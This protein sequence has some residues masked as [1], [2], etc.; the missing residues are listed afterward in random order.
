MHRGSLNKYKGGTLLRK[1]CAQ[2][3]F[4][5]ELMLGLQWK[6][7]NKD[8]VTHCTVEVNKKKKLLLIHIEVILAFL[9]YYPSIFIGLHSNFGKLA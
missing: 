1:L 8:L 4:V 3:T 7:S 2:Y 9:S 6:P 5:K